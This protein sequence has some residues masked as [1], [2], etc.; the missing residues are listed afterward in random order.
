[1]GKAKCHFL[2]GPKKVRS[3]GNNIYNKEKLRHY[4]GTPPSAFITHQ[5]RHTGNG[6]TSVGKVG[7]GFRPSWIS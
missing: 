6:L 4:G 2:N 3:M 5:H 7:S 1:M